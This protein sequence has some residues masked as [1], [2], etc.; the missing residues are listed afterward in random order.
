MAC[1]PSC[2]LP[3]GVPAPNARMKAAADRG[4]RQHKALERSYLGGRIW[5]ALASVRPNEIMD[6]TRAIDNKPPIREFQHWPMVEVEVWYHP[7]ATESM[8]GVPNQ[9]HHE[10]ADPPPEGY[11]R[12]TMDLMGE[13][14]DTGLLAV[15]DH[16]SG[17]PAFQ[18]PPAVSAQHRH[19]VMLYATHPETAARVM[20]EGAKVG[21]Y[22]TKL[23]GLP[24]AKPT[25]IVTPDEIGEFM[26][27]YHD[28]AALLDAVEAGLI[29]DDKL[30]EP[31]TNKFCT[32]CPAAPYCP[33]F[34][35]QQAGAA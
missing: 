12:G 29:P 24:G 15:W 25:H 35:A 16:K 22:L 34:Q 19:G 9:C 33:A 1:P 18:T 10:S 11:Y 23:A 6:A 14:P 30:P 27:K 21:T 4:T 5:D 2:W 20:H 13:D 28:L 32:F 7:M 26:D 8:F 31:E 3:Q 17:N